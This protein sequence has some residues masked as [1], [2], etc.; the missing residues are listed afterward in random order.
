MVAGLLSLMMGCVGPVPAI[1]AVITGWMALAQIKKNPY[2]TSGK[3]MAIIGVVT[4]GLIVVLSLLFFLWF[5]LAAVF[6]NL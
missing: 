4:G 2:T 3:P 1:V 6:G 5:I